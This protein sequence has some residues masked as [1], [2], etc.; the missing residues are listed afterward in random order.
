[1]PL[2]SAPTAVSTSWW[3]MSQAGLSAAVCLQRPT[4][5]RM[6][7]PSSL[8]GPTCAP[9]ITLVL[10]T[11]TTARAAACSL[12]PAEARLTVSLTS[13]GGQLPTPAAPLARRRT[14]RCVCMRTVGRIR[15]CGST[16]STGLPLLA[17][18]ITRCGWEASKVTVA[19]GFLPRTS[20]YRLGALCRRTSRAPTRYQRVQRQRRV[21]HQVLRQA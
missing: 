20:V 8:C 14:L 13:S 19:Q 6:T 4:L 21:R 12:R 15:T 5:D 11:V 9:I 7:T 16:W 3:Q 17:L 18:R 1:M 10:V 2:T